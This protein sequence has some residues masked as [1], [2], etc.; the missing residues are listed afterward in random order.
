MVSGR[1]RG[2]YTPVVF[3][4][5]DLKEI[6]DNESYG[7]KGMWAFHRNFH[8]GHD[9][10]RIETID[11]CDWVVGILWNNF[12]KG[13]ELLT[14]NSIDYDDPLH[15]SDI[16]ILKNSS[17]AVMIFTGEYHP[18]LEYKDYI[19]EIVEKEFPKLQEKGI[20]QNIGLF[21]SLVY[22]IAI[23]LTIHEIYK[24]KLDYHASCGK[25][26]WRFYRYTDWCKERFG[27]EIEMTEP[28]T[29][30][31]GNNYS[32]M[33]NRIEPSLIKRINKK[34]IHSHFKNIDDVKE[35][36]KDIEGL[37][38]EFFSIDNNWMHVRFYFNDKPE[39]TWWTEAI[40]LK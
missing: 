20:K 37:K 33:K 25:D 3:S 13:M 31:F 18:F 12:A 2:I 36:I 24:I 27:I 15:I 28:V 19:F 17:D 23:R 7:Y 16:N 38:I 6:Y 14:G 34:L 21:N 26:L 40:K 4:L 8:P 30:Q 11:K 22:S 39:S 5:K 32:N 29:D 9:Q 35:H 10:C 1:K